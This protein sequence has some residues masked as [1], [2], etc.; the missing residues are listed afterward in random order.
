MSGFN[1][2]KDLAEALE[3]ACVQAVVNT[4]HKAQTN[5]QD[6]IQAN[7]QVKTGRMYLG[8]YNVSAEGSNRPHQDKMLPEVQKPSKDTEAIVVAGTEY[9]VHQNFGTVHMAGRAFFGPGMERTKPY[10]EQ[11]LEGVLKKLERAA[12]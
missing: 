4:A 11:Q 6:V 10:L 12:K 1:H 8:I 7:R 3:P 9:S 5:I 2:W